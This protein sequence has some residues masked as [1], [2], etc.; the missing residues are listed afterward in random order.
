MFHSKEELEAL[1]RRIFRAYARLPEINGARIYSV[2]PDIM[3]SK[4]FK[5]RIDY[6]RLS[7]DGTILGASAP[8]M[9]SIKT[10]SVKGHETEYLIDEKTV[11]VDRSLEGQEREAGRRNFTIF[12]EI[13]HK[14][15]MLA[16]PEDY[17][18]FLQ[19]PAAMYYK[20][21]YRNK[22]SQFDTYEWQANNLASAIQL[23][24]EL[25]RQAMYICGIEVRIEVLNKLS[26]R[27]TY[28]KFC[29][30]A[31]FLGCSGTALAIRMKYMG[32]LDKDYF[33]NPEEICD[34]NTEE[35]I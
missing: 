18:I 34:I 32:L 31:R 7:L 16:F 20:P 5:L 10:F 27:E 17:S 35:L 29:E 26:H 22:N 12:H 21:F 3:A 14:S 1:A 15:L 6:R 24:E 23:P 9:Q 2:S 8:V 28:V 11:V 30:M 4:Q 33:N 25:V 13:A 19:K